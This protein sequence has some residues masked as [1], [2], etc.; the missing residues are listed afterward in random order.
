MVL[1]LYNSGLKFFYH[2]IFFNMHYRL[3]KYRSILGSLPRKGT[4]TQDF[5]YSRSLKCPLHIAPYALKIRISVM[6]L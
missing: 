2:L 6:E 5:K 3:G 4:S 1:K